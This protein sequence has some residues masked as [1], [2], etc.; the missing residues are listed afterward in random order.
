MVHCVYRLQLS[1]VS[2]ASVYERTHYKNSVITYLF[3][4]CD[5]S[6]WLFCLMWHVRAMI[7]V[8]YTSTDS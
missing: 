6:L 4:D 2:Y 5:R 7:K 3:Y 1:V 8:Q